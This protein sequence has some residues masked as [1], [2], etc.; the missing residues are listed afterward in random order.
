MN[1]MVHTANEIAFAENWLL[2]RAEMASADIE[3]MV[4]M[5]LE[6]AGVDAEIVKQIDV[7]FDEIDSVGVGLKEDKYIDGGVNIFI[8]EDFVCTSIEVWNES[9]LDEKLLNK[10]I[11]INNALSQ[12]AR[13]QKALTNY[14]VGLAEETAKY[15]KIA[16]I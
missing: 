12:D 9:W 16:N 1:K 14:M 4:K 3:K 2:E 7:M 10:Y 11:I 13:F 6:A 8:D 15:R 5:H